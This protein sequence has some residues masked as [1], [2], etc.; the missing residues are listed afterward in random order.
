[1]KIKHNCKGII[2][3]GEN[4]RSARIIKL[5]IKPHGNWYQPFMYNNPTHDQFISR[6]LIG[7]QSPCMHGQAALITSL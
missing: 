3:E 7:A 4:L 5:K 1:M 2:P 6:A